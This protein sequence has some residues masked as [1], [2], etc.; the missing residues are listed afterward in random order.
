MQVKLSTSSKLDHSHSQ[1]EI[2]FLNLFQGQN[3]GPGMHGMGQQ[4]PNSKGKVTVL[5][6]LHRSV[7]APAFLNIDTWCLLRCGY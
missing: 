3:M 5:G 4:G 1:P 2:H 6:V 7:L